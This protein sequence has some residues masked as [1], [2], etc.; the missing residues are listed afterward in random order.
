MQAK[1][2]LTGV[3]ISPIKMRLI[4]NLV[5]GQAATEASNLL[6]FTPKK[7]ARILGKLIQSAVANAKE[8]GEVDTDNLYIKSIL[9]DH[10]PLMKRWMARA[11]GSANRILKKTSHITVVV[12][13]R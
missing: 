4:A 3:H 1:A 12:E 7:G 9:V 13:E 11:R 5:R 10:G 2:K 6:R 8:R